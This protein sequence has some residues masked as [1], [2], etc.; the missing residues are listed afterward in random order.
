VAW[1]NAGD[2]TRDEARR[3]S[4]E[5]RHTVLQEQYEKLAKDAQGEVIKAARLVATTLARFRLVKAVRDGPYDVVLIDEVGA[6]TLPEVLLAVAKA[7]KCAVL[8]GDFMQ[9]G[10]ILPGALENSDRTD[11]RRWLVT[12]STWP[13]LACSTACT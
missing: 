5:E 6:A 12:C 10:P 1:R 4:V 7:S 9:L 2:I 11:I 13:P 3:H 8:L